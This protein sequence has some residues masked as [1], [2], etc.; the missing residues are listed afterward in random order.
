MNHDIHI[1]E[2]EMES[3]DQYLDHSLNE[4]DLSAFQAKLS[5]PEWAEKVEYVRLLRTGIAAAALRIKME[6]FHAGIQKGK[7]RRMPAMQWKWMAA[8]AVLLIL[9]GIWLT[10]IFGNKAHQLYDKYYI[11]DSGLVISMGSSNNTIEYSF[12]RGMVEYKSENYEMALKYW[13]TLAPTPKS[14]TLRYFIGSALMANEQM[15]E[16]LPY[17]EKIIQQSESIFQKDAFWYAGLIYLRK[18]EK[19]KARKLIELSDNENKDDVLEKI[20]E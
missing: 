2:E 17:F 7:I 5:D 12:N 18:G 19:M 15:R 1:P 14:D 9:G 4:G 20:K 8:A 10:R 16:A 11:P 13:N 3:I 6:E